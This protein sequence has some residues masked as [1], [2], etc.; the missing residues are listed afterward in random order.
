MTTPSD[1]DAIAASNPRTSPAELTRIAGSRPDL[2]SAIYANPATHR[3]LK[4]WLERYHPEAVAKGPAAP[5]APNATQV[6]VPGARSSKRSRTSLWTALV[7]TI[8]LVAAGVV[9][10]FLWLSDDYSAP[11]ATETTA[12]RQSSP[13]AA[14]QAQPRP[15]ET[16]ASSVNDADFRTYFEGIASGDPNTIG[17]VSDL[18]APGSQA[19][20]Y[21]TYYTAASK[22]ARD[23]GFPFDREIVNEVD[24]G[25]MMCPEGHAADNS[26]MTYTN[27][28]TAGSHLVDFDISGTPLSG[29]LALGDGEFHSL[30]DLGSARLIASYKSVSNN[31]VVVFDVTSTSENLWLDASYTGPDGRTSQPTMTHRTQLPNGG[32]GTVA[33][34]FK[35]SVFGGTVLI[36]PSSDSSEGPGVTFRSE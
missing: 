9:F 32:S 29:R 13:T 16:T 23:S 20:A 8:S 19:A 33:F 36:R 34:Y 2:L 27:L 7:V 25:F 11:T 30:G 14:N 15:A 10:G 6:A 18:A 17:G 24:D 21:I 4:E 12:P 26:C 22:A 35:G 31:V 3:G 28:Q 5:Q 1:K